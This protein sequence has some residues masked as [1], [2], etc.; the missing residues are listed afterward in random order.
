M[1]PENLP[2][3]GSLQNEQLA[4]LLELL[5]NDLDRYFHQLVLHTQHRLYIFVLRQTGS[6]QDAEDIVQEAFIRAYHALANYS[7]ERIRVMQLQAWLYKI[8]LHIVYRQSSNSA[9]LQCMPLDLS[10]ESALLTIEDA[11][12]Q[13]PEKAL[14]G[15]ENLHELEALI[16]QLPEQYR[17]AVNCYYV[18]DLSYREIA[19]LL[20]QPL[21]T[22]KSNVHRGIQ[23]L[24]KIALSTQV[25]GQY[26]Q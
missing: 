1:Q 4:D 3:T 19:D 21:G 16:S 2:G 14:E 26:A 8:T 9:R 24:R 6:P 5:A 15:R 13:Q 10:E 17:V 18:A 22:I 20:H 12:Y 23:L 7:P 11:E 25:R